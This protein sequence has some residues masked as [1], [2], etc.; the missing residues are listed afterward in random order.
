M[1]DHKPWPQLQTVR[2]TYLYY[3]LSEEVT[4]ADVPD[5]RIEQNQILVP[6]TD[7]SKRTPQIE[8]RGEALAQFCIEMKPR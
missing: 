5:N 7:H 8:I 3:L 2:H 1:P 6:L 4:E